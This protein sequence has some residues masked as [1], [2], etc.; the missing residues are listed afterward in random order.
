ML[1]HLSFEAAD[2]KRRDICGENKPSLRW[3]V[4]TIRLRLG[5]H[6]EVDINSKTG[7]TND[8]IYPPLFSLL[9]YSNIVTL[10]PCLVSYYID[11][12]NK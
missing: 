5:L 4:S 9:K 11:T 10:F 3:A 8:R 6:N 12:K 7:K 1:K 2:Y